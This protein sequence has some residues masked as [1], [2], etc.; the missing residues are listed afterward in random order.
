ML[1]VVTFLAVFPRC[2]LAAL[3]VRHELTLLVVVIAI[4]VITDVIAPVLFFLLLG[5]L[6][7]IVFLFLFTDIFFLPSDLGDVDVDIE[8]RP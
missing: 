7:V 3:C 8:V 4:Y 2:N 1:F 6:L 5:R